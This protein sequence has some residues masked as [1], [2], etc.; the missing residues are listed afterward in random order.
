M[1]ATLRQ[2]VQDLGVALDEIVVYRKRGKKAIIE[3]DLARPQAAQK[4][5]GGNV[6]DKIVAMSENI[7]IK[8]WSLNHDHYLYGAPK[9]S[10]IE[11]HE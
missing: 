11:N 8:D 10:G 1:T 6:F 3:I 7:G 2:A 9:R 4:E 5:T